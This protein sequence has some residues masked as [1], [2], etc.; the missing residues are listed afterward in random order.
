MVISAA[1]PVGAED[2]AIVGISTLFYFQY[3]YDTDKVFLGIRVFAHRGIGEGRF[4][5]W[6]TCTEVLH[7]SGFTADM[8]PVLISAA[9]RSWLC[10]CQ[11]Q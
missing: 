5:D 8:E 1:S 11:C 9:H 6:S 7:E 4:Y 2:K 3:Q 10:L